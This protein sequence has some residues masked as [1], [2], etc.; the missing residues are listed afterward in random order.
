MYDKLEPGNLFCGT[1]VIAIFIASNNT[2][3]KV[4]IWLDYNQNYRIVYINVIK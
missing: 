2:S 4:R 3:P 1:G